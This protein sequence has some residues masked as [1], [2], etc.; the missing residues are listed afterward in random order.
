MTDLG[1]RLRII[2]NNEIQ[3]LYGFP[4]F[5][6]EEREI[7]FSLNHSEEKELEH[8][9]GV[10]S[11]VYF[12]LQMGYFKAKKMFFTFQF[13]EVKEDLN[14]I[15]ARYFTQEE[16]VKRDL[17]IS[18]KNILQERIIKFFNYQ[19]CTQENK[20]ILQEKAYYLATIHANPIYIFKELLN[21]LVSQ[22]IVLPGYSTLQNIVSNAITNEIGR[23]EATIMQYIS[24][25]TQKVLDKLLSAED[26]LYEI[27]FLKKEPR[28]FRCKEI[29]QEVS[30][31]ESLKNLYHIARS[32]LITS[33]I[34]NENIKY[35]ASLVGYYT[36]YKLKRMRNKT[37]YVYLICFIFNRYQKINDNLIHTFI[38]YVSKYIEEAKKTARDDIY[39]YKMEGNKHL[40]NAGKV[41]ELFIDETIPEEIEFKEVKKIAFELIEKNKFSLLSRYISKVKF[42]D[43]EY[44]WD[45]Y[46]KLAHTFKINLRY[47][48]LNIDFE[49][50]NPQ[51]PFMKAVLLLKETFCK[52]KSLNQ[53]ASPQLP[54]EFIPLKLKK[55][56]YEIETVKVD[57][58]TCK[59]KKLNV[60]KYEF[61][62]YRFLK[63]RLES[64]EIF[65]RESLNFKSFEE[66]IIDN[67]RWKNKE[68]LIQKIAL[69]CLSKPINTLLNSF[70]EE[71]NNKIYEVNKR[72]K[73]GKNPHIKITGKGDNVKWSLIYKKSE[74]V[75]NNSIYEQ[76]PQM[77][78]SDV[79]F[80]VNK[81]SD[82]MTSFSHILDRYVKGNVDNHRI[83][84]CIVAYGT[85]MGLSKMADISDMTSHELVST[86]NSFIRLEN[87]KAAND[88]I[89][90]AMVKL[91]IF[92]YY[93]I[94]E[95]TI[96]SSSDGQKYETQF[97]T[98]SS[99]Y[100]PKYFGLNKG[101]TSY[102]LVANHIPINAK[103]IGANEHESHYVFDLLF[104]NT[105]ELIPAI[106]S[107]DT[108]G[109]NQVNFILLYL[110]GY[111]F[112]P[113]YRN[114]SN[115]AK[116]IYSFKNPSEYKDC[117]FTPIKKINTRLIEEEWENIEK[118]I[119][120]LALKS[121]TQSTI[122]RK[123]SSYNRKNRTKKA[124]WELDNIVSS[125]YILNYI[126]SQELRQNIQKVL[127]R[128]ELYHK[129]KRAICYDNFGK[130]R[131]KTELEQQIWSE[132]TRL[133][134]NSIIFYN[135]FILSRLLEN[136]EKIKHTEKMDLIKKISPIAWRH[137]NFYGQYEFYRKDISIDV[138]EIINTLDTETM[139]THMIDS[140]QYLE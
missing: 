22:R 8:L 90:N 18:T 86:A 108:H 78:I 137:I 91:P 115:K 54:S 1:K 7:Y 47:I 27:T 127:N 94:K 36:V 24:K 44:E 92:K 37:V 84:A 43:T 125:I 10:P 16:I 114:L 51:D 11:K 131:V 77:R 102:T 98:I 124:L 105:S 73:E 62:I 9:R 31:R 64:G 132:C 81:H 53:L 14:Y 139:W 40:K 99:R 29:M 88:K 80:F 46:I 20:K 30:K 133:I 67:E 104:N 126:D 12:I 107:T 79:L 140:D 21:Y 23:L 60:D 128:G 3:E 82:F 66:D 89:S 72:I 100:S 119:V 5:T 134:A 63:A 57:G 55:Y 116:M 71:L 75:I 34:S 136:T 110:F 58:K 109:V 65:I 61:L 59:I 135:A 122:I 74:E 19:H 93:N 70:K 26:G 32:F 56:L 38:Y 129:L 120:S 96:H 111:M 33:G 83:A 28:D 69:P 15:F 50:H 97:D 95:D 6:C 101:I 68:E 138:E 121:T 117:F 2:T 118:I 130:F 35:Y 85:N 123:L 113:R 49:S 25:E 41:L 112:A 39:K 17:P 87:L 13:H 103:I 76:M 52:N 42:D 106:H 4:H 48:F 45:H